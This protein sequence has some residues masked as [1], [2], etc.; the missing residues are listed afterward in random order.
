M[1]AWNGV[2]EPGED[3]FRPCSHCGDEHPEGVLED[4]LCPCCVDIQADF[5]T[6]L[7][8]QETSEDE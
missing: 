7:G 5:D 2:Y 1:S 6:E 4:G 8:R 3:E